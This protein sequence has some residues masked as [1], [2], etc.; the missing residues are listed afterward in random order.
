VANVFVLGQRFDFATFDSAD[1]TPTGGE[2]NET[3]APSQLQSMASS[4]AT[5]GMFGS[6]SI[7]M[8]AR[9][10]TEDL[11]AIRNATPPGGSR[12]LMATAS[13]TK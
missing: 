1:M 3:G 6:G 10:I 9:Q 4:R 8:L 7:E 13:Q 2:M 12:A 5:L 11:Q